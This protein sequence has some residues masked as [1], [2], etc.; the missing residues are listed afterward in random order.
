MFKISIIFFL[1]NINFIYS[2][3]LNNNEEY[4]NKD[5]NYLFY[6]NDKNLS[7][8]N[9]IDKNYSSKSSLLTIINSID[10]YNSNSGNNQT[11]LIKENVMKTYDINEMKLFKNIVRYIFIGKS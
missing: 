3:Y 11:D 8:K 2:K 10:D 4:K 7:S 6:L 1:I 5:L 9:D